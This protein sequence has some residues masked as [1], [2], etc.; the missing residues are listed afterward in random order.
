MYN[1]KDELIPANFLVKET[2][3]LQAMIY[4]RNEERKKEKEERRK[5]K[6]RKK[7]ELRL[8]AIEEE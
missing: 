8:M 2:C 7:Q 5:E 6:K 4:E 3:K 1:Y